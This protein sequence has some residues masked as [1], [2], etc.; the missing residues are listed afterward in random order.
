M[1]LRPREAGQAARAG[2]GQEPRPEGLR[3]EAASGPGLLAGRCAERG[4]VA[5]GLT[6][7]RGR[8]LPMWLWCSVSRLAGHSAPAASPYSGRATCWSVEMLKASYL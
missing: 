2:A 7:R 3:K 4:G 5:C 8:P 1:E 6:A